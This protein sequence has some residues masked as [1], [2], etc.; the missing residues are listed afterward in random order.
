MIMA[1]ETECIHW[2]HDLAFI[3]CLLE[4]Q[5]MKMS[6]L[7]TEVDFSVLAAPP[8]GHRGTLHDPG[9]VAEASPISLTNTGERACVTNTCHLS[10]A[11]LDE[12][13]IASWCGTHRGWFRHISLFLLLLWKVFCVYL[14]HRDDQW[15]PAVVLKH[16][17][18][19]STITVVLQKWC[20]VVLFIYVFFFFPF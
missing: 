14:M 4:Q 13:Q 19:Y 6:S 18:P 3:W 8:A 15:A 5:H 20:W 10:S 9:C 1:L 16:Q 11:S 17:K 12:E 2:V 7:W